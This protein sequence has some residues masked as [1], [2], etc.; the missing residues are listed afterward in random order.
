[1]TVIL[2][3]P[4]KG[5]LQEQAER[6]FMRAGLKVVR[7]G[8]ARHYRG[9]FAG[10]DA[11]EIAFLSAS[12]IARALGE[13]D[14]H[15]GVTGLDLLQ[16]TLP[17][18]EQSC[19]VVTDLGFGMADVVVAVPRAWID[20]AD[21]ADLTDVASD[22][23]RRHGRYLR[24]ATKYVNLTRR[25]LQT[26]RLDDYRIVESAGATEGAPASGSADLIVDITTT[27]AT[28]AANK[29]KVVRDG[30][31]LKSQAHLLAALTADWSSS[32][33]HAVVALLERIAAERTARGMRALTGR[34]DDPEGA[35]AEAQ[36]FGAS[37]PFGAVHP[38]TLYCPLDAVP[39]GV[40]LLRRRG[41]MDV[42]VCVLD[43][44]YA[45]RNSLLD[46]LLKRLPDGDGPAEAA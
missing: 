45:K 4:S 2:A 44:I 12:Q 18:S 19:H 16:E 7:E 41:A 28:L 33:R 3:L 46:P 31:I 5:R 9:R 25:F 36:S 21:M 6:F 22:M 27:G 40:S 35:I 39:D 37:A 17:E 15:L 23:R 13:G 24:I 10:L 42:G 14:V 20:V 38:L 11:V 26:H 8:G 34:V 30:V 1:M 29:L 32:A 43:A